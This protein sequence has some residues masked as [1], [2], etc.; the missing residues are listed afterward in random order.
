LDGPRSS[1]TT[2]TL[3]RSL[4]ARVAPDVRNAVVERSY[5]NRRTLSE[6]TEALLRQALE[7]SAA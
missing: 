1:T 2:P 6:E 5:E 7:A 3:G 4:K